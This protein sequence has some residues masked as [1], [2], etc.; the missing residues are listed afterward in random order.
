MKIDRHTTQDELLKL[1]DA[2]LLRDFLR[3]TPLNL[4]A[5]VRIGLLFMLFPGMVLGFRVGMA[6]T[7]VFAALLL[8]LLLWEQEAWG[9]AAVRCWLIAGIIIVLCVSGHVMI[10]AWQLRRQRRQFLAADPALPAEG[11]VRDPQGLALAW[12]EEEGR[13]V[14]ELVLDIPARGI[15][16][17]LFTV[18]DYEGEGIGA[19]RALEACLSQGEGERSLRHH[20]FFAY[21]F[22][23]GRH[24]LSWYT[25]SLKGGAPQAVF[26][27]LNEVK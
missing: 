2:A 25:Q 8:G 27:Q 4:K 17:Y 15:Y 9:V 10:T 16:A 13:Y 24:R 12:R 3:G 21:R 23:P 26:T 22:E 18:E 20:H 6:I 14:S 7:G 1:T 11:A 19:D 5:F